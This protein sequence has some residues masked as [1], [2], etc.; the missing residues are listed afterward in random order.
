MLAVLITVKASHSFVGLRTPPA[1]NV[2]F[3]WLSIITKIIIHNMSNQLCD[4]LICDNLNS[5]NVGK[6]KIL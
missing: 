4:Q 3:K 2:H 1:Q 6:S 5:Y